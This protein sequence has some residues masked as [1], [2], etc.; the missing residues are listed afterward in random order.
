[1]SQW[2]VNIRQ[3]ETAIYLVDNSERLVGGGAGNSYGDIRIHRLRLTSFDKPLP[4]GSFSLKHRERWLS[5]INLL[6]ACYNW[7]VRLISL[8]YL[9]FLSINVK[10]LSLMISN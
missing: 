3:V 9:N 5:Q 1:M 10:L 2:K 4:S 7:S 8:G 6:N